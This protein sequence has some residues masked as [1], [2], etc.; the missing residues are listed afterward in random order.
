MDL[1]AGTG[2]KIE[3]GLH[4]VLDPSHQAVRALRIVANAL[5]CDS[6]RAKYG[7]SGTLSTPA[8]T[9]LRRPG[10]PDSFCSLYF[11]RPASRGVFV[12]DDDVTGTQ[13]GQ[14]H[15]LDVEAEALAIDGDAAPWPFRGW[16]RRAQPRSGIRLVQVSSMNTKREMSIRWR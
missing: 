3:A 5:S 11:L 15:F 10:P 6:V 16:P 14:Q 13:C 8:V 2:A 4:R 7:I 9:R 1:L 12:H